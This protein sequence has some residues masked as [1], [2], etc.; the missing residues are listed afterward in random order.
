MQPK[1]RDLDLLR[2]LCRSESAE[3][4]RRIVDQLRGHAWADG[5]RKI[6][7]EACARLAHRGARIRKEHVAREVTLAGFP[8]VEL[9]ALFAAAE[10]AAEKPRR[11]GKSR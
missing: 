7:F 2:T 1:D 11:Q 10:P 8:D 3:Q 9:D 5:E 4:A 6:I